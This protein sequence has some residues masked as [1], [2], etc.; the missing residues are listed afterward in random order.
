MPDRITAP[1]VARN[2]DHILE[3]LRGVLPDSGTVLEIASGS[4]EHVVHFAPHF[5]QI[6]FHPTDPDERAIASIKGWIREAASPNIVAPLM[7]DVTEGKWPF[8]KLDGIICINMT[9]ISPWRA[10]EAL[11]RGAAGALKHGAPLYLYGPYRRRNV[12]TAPSN[13]EFDQHLRTQNSEWGL[14]NLEIVSI[15]AQSVGFM[16]PD[17]TEMPANNLSIVFRRR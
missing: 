3:V 10:T 15:L 12:P 6:E 14:R 2:R 5:P 1:A 8:K 17:I 9:H 13:E 4:G 11:M 16:K 7:F